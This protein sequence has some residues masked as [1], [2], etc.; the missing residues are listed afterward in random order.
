MR[1]W[2]YHPEGFA[3]DDPQL[4]IDPTKGPY[5]N[6]PRLCYKD[7]LTWLTGMVGT[8]QFLWCCTVADAWLPLSYSY[9]PM[10][11]ELDVPASQILAYI[12]E[13][14]WDGILKDRNRD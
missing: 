13:P 2:T 1:L 8:D 11:S 3:V 12:L 4:H 14:V 7:A 6:E 9:D 10:K 5:W